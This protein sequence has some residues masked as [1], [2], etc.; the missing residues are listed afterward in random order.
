MN[1]EKKEFELDQLGKARL[2]AIQLR[3]ELDLAFSGYVIKI[4]SFTFFLCLVLSSL[5]IH[6]RGETMLSS[7]GILTL[8]ASIVSMLTSLHYARKAQASLESYL[9]DTMRRELNGEE[10][11]FYSDYYRSRINFF[12]KAGIA[13]SFVGITLALLTII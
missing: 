5:S 12:E 2:Q 7:M 6:T 4:S 3:F 9:N 10:P 13:L 1:K 8:F 11:G